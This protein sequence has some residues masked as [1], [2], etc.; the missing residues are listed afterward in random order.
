MGSGVGSGVGEGGRGNYTCLC[1]TNK[2]QVSDT[3]SV[4]ERRHEANLNSDPCCVAVVENVEQFE[5]WR[6]VPG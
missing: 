1:W 6:L 5:H 4:Q 3:G 2:V